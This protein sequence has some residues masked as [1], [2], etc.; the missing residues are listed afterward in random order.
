MTALLSIV[1]GGGFLVIVALWF[2][3]KLGYWDRKTDERLEDAARLRRQNEVLN[4]P[5]TDEQLQK[6]LRDGTF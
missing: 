5:V 4:R 6:S 2:S 1:G 3:Y